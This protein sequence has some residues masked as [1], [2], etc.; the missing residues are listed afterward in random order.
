MKHN[1][2]EDMI[3]SKVNTKE[4][5]EVVFEIADHAKAHFDFAKN[6]QKEAFEKNLYKAFFPIVKNN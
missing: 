3:Y 1:V 5:E 6:H 2:T 4:I